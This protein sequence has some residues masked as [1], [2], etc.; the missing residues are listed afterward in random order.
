MS[1]DELEKA[2]FFYDSVAKL[3]EI[4]TRAYE[5]SKEKIHIILGVLSTVIPI[6]TGVGY[7]ILSSVFSLPFFILFVI[8]LGSFVGALGRGVLLLEP[9]W[10]LYV[11]VKKLIQR[12]EKKPLS[13]ILF[14]VSSTWNDT[15]EKN[16]SVINSLRSGIKQ[17]VILIIVGL[18]LLIIAFLAI[19]TELYMMRMQNDPIS[20]FVLQLF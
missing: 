3:E 19:G 7:Y 6:S 4:S 11:N 14:K 1:Q 13:F 5:R 10:F 15:I 16:I 18:T 20:L 9:K 12:Y 2:K 8:S 17:M